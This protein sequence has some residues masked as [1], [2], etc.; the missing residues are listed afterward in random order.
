MKV[1]LGSFAAL[2]LLVGG[3]SLYPCQ[4]V[5]PFIA[6]IEKMK[7]STHPL[8]FNVYN[9][10]GNYAGS[11]TQVGTAFLVEE[12]KLVTADHVLDQWQEK[13][14]EQYPQMTEKLTVLISI[15]DWSGRPAHFK[16]RKIE[17][18]KCKRDHDNDIAICSLKE[19]PFLLK[20][21]K[22]YVRPV[23]LESELLPDGTAVAY[24][25]FPKNSGVHLV[26][27]GFV[28]GYT[29]NIEDGKPTMILIHGIAWDGNSGSPVYLSDG[30]VV[31]MVSGKGED[32]SVGITVARPT[33]LIIDLLNKLDSPANQVE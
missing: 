17:T 1:L 13:L 22:A 5:D 33:Y 23:Q 32:D 20:E 12:G 19:N 10:A 7:L 15:T 2:W 16:Q 30:R 28:M 31:G 24:S 3:L 18:E 4:E 9:L 25:G 8:V 21:T 29:D 6:Q 26:G 27:R 11:T 14:A